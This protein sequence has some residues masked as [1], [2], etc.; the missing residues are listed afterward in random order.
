MTKETT[1]PKKLDNDGFEKLVEDCNFHQF[2]ENPIF[3]GRYS[4]T[5]IM[6]E[7][8]N[9]VHVFYDIDEKP[10]LIANNYTIEKAIEKLE[11]MDSVNA[12]MKIEYLGTTE[13]SNGRKFNHFNVAYKK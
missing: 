6:E 2:K 12:L 13:K 4:E 5:K 9:T 7:S 10:W 11:E 1:T 3:V 8:G